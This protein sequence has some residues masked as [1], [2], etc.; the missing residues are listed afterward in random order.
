MGLTKD[1]KIPEKSGFQ[2]RKT[3]HKRR[4]FDDVLVQPSIKITQKKKTHK[5]THFLRIKNIK[6]SKNKFPSFLVHIKII[7]KL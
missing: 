1:F 7:L 2:R 4:F 5:Q 6:R 3:L